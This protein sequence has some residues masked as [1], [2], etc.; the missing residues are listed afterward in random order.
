[1]LLLVGGA[2][3][4]YAQTAI[5]R[6]T[7][8]VTSVSRIAVSGTPQPL[9]VSTATP[10]QQPAPVVASGG[11]YSITTNETNRKITAA[12]DQDL[13]A[14][15]TLEVALAA[16]AAA[17]SVGSVALSTT[18]ADVV[19]DIATVNATSLPITYRLIANTTVEMP[20]AET[21]VVTFTILAAP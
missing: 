8:Q 15:V 13:P 14:G 17:T 2:Q 1:M 20:S 4:T 9:V 3:A 19:T 18:G 11:T 16:P 12:V 5:Q 6:V 10:G 21:R 7:F